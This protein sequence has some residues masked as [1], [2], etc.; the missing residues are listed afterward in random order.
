M[1][2]HVD[3]ESRRV[4]VSGWDEDQNVFV[5]ITSLYNEDGEKAYILLRRQARIGEMIFVRLI[6]H[7]G[8]GSP[9][10]VAFEVRRASPA[11]SRG[12]YHKVQIARI[13]WSPERLA[14]TGLRTSAGD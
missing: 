9:V 11:D 8:Y 13:A 12:V 5:E 7:S 6:E 2:P 4:E 10:P 3:V 14:V 1:S